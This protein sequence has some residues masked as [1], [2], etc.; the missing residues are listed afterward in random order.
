VSVQ[1]SSGS[2]AVESFVRVVVA[3]FALGLAG[4]IGGWVAAVESPANQQPDLL[5]GAVGMLVI[6]VVVLVAA[7]AVAGAVS[8][9]GHGWLGF[10]FAMAGASAACAVAVAVNSSDAVHWG[11][12][13]L[14]SIDWLADI[15]G[16]YLSLFASPGSVQRSIETHLRSPRNLSPFEEVH[17]MRA[18]LSAKKLRRSLLD[19]AQSV[20]VNRNAA[21]PV[22]Q[23]AV[24]LLGRH[25]DIADQRLIARHHLDDPELARA[26]VIGLQAA[27]PRLRGS[28]M[29]DIARTYPETQPLI[30]RVKGL[31]SPY[32]P[33]FSC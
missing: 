14:G 30:D 1:E 4:T 19:Y 33:T 25:G 9:R 22:R 27:N 3:P 31:K 21:V 2:G 20:V 13:R 23:W 18:L 6:F 15:V 7:G 10:L 32:W 28:A 29:S 17:L 5:T 24:L 12:S 8:G 11:L 16:P 26:C